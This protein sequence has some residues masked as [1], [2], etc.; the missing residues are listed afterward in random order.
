M[1]KGRKGD[2]NDFV[3]VCDE[4]NGSGDRRISSSP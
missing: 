1:N 2:E 4:K 3:D